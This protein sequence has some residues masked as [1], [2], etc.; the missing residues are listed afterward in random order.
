[1]EDINYLNDFENINFSSNCSYSLTKPEDGFI[2]D[3]LF[4]LFFC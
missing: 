1:M 2:K 4:K 3:Y